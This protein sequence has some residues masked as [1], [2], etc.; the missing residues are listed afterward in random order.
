M[1]TDHYLLQASVTAQRA[2][3]I[4]LS[5][6]YAD[7][8]EGRLAAL[9]L[10][11]SDVQTL[12]LMLWENGVGSAPDPDAQMGA[13]GDALTVSMV[14]NLNT[15]RARTSVQESVEWARNSLASTFDESVHELLQQR[16]APIDHLAALSAP[17]SQDSMVAADRRLAGRTP[18]ELVA[19]LLEAAGDCMAV[20]S[21]MAKSGD[22]AGAKLQA[23]QADLA[24][25]EAYL[26]DAAVRMGDNALVTVELRWDLGMLAD[27]P[28][29][30]DEGL[31]ATVGDLRAR[32]LGVVGPAE[33]PV[34]REWFQHV[35]VLT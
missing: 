20:A 32:L 35:D 12:Q 33:Q 1:P 31:Q 17:R 18:A 3:Y 28:P 29:R 22:V 25:F 4:E 15:G 7:A 14:E 2:R 6:T 27:E 9:A 23:R 30:P 10:W 5:R 34:L 24:S 26:V 21:A 19:Q 16:F 13:V 11:A 8:G